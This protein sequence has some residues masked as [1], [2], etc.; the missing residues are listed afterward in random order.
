MITAVLLVLW[1]V[2]PA[3]EWF[4]AFVK[5]EP[6]RLPYTVVYFLILFGLVV[7]MGGWSK[8]HQIAFVLL[9]GAGLGQ[10]AGMIAIFIANLFIPNG[11]ARTA[12]TLSQDGMFAVFATDFTVAIV[13]GGW[14]LCAA[15]M[16]AMKVAMSRWGE[17]LKMS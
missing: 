4:R 14:L 3:S 13:L 15:A 2:P 6:M 10:V 7:S 9:V 17:S 1:L 12:A 8:R 5:L 16:A 11:I